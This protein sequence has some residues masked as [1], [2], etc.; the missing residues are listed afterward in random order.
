MHCLLILKPKFDCVNRQ[1]LRISRKNNVA[2]GKVERV[3]KIYSERRK[4]RRIWKVL[5]RKGSEA[6]K[7][8]I[9]K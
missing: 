1:F 5:V 7:I 4:E 6:S 3:M 9:L 8:Y 2:N